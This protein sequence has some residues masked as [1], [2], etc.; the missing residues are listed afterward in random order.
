MAEILE[1]F[2]H[3]QS[4]WL[5][6]LGRSVIVDGGLKRLINAGLRG[7][8]SNPTIFEKA[9]AGSTDYDDALRQRLAKDGKAD[10]GKIYEALAIEDIQMAADILRPVYDES[11]GED[12]YVSLEVSPHLAHDTD[13]TVKEGRRLG[14]QLQRPNIMIKVPATLEGLPAVRQLIA[15][16]IN[17]NVTLLFGLERYRQVV[18][19]FMAGHEDRVSAGRPLNGVASVASFFLSRIDVL[20]DKKLDAL[21]PSGAAHDLRGQAAIAYA[22]LAYQIYKEWTAGDRWRRLAARAAGPVIT[23]AISDVVG[24]EA[25]DIGSGP[26]VADATT[27]ADARRV[28]AAFEE[29]RARGQGIAVLDGRMVE[30]LHVAE[31]RALV[32][33]AEAIAARAGTAPTSS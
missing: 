19:A 3:G 15:A 30:A 12:G 26:T 7:V 25:S 8:T 17:V 27:F 18:E 4:P 5:D 31:A 1:L 16:G 6:Y 2:R 23:F 28:I 24:D 11:A 13:R 21:G 10:V 22:R 9:I 20:V 29:A 33:Y 14:E 32:A